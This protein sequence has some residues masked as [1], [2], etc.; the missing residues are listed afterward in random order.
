MLDALNDAP[1]AFKAA[2]PAPA[3]K[4]GTDKSDLDDGI[5]F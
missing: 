3:A 4:A 5:P 1:D 2:W